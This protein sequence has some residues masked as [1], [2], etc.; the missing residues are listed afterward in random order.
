MRYLFLLSFCF[1]CSCSST[2]STDAPLSRSSRISRIITVDLKLNKDGQYSLLPD[3][4]LV[5]IG[6]E[7]K[8]VD[9][10]I[11]NS[12]GRLQFTGKYKPGI[13]R[14]EI[15]SKEY[16]GFTVVD[17]KLDPEFDVEVIVKALNR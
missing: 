2:P 10:A 9:A 4:K 6:I 11:T 13:Y 8:P 16:V 7:G 1:I 5:F 15:D 14:I 12:K 17:M 3:Q